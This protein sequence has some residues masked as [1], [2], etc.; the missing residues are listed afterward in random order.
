MRNIFTIQDL[1]IVVRQMYKNETNPDLKKLYLNFG[2]TIK[3]LL[4][5]DELTY[6]DNFNKKETKNKIF[7]NM[8]FIKGGN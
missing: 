8:L 3:N 7:G 1:L 5:C 4:D 6:F 2:L